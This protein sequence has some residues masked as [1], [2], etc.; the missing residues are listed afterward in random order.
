M[1]ESAPDEESSRIGRFEQSM[2]V[3][4][5]CDAPS[6]DFEDMIGIEFGQCQ[7]VSM[8]NINLGADISLGPIEL[9]IDGQ[10]YEFS[11]AA[12][13]VRLEHENADVHSASRYRHVLSEGRLAASVSEKEHKSVGSEF[14]LD[15]RATA[16]GG[17]GAGISGFWK[18]KS[19]KESESVVTVQPEIVF[20]EPTGQ[21]LWQVG[22]PNGDPRRIE[23]DLRGT[24]ISS[25][26]NDEMKPLCSLSARDAQQP[27]TGRVSIEASATDFRLRSKSQRNPY[28]VS[29]AV[30]DSVRDGLAEDH[31]AYLKRSR[32]AEDRLKERV[33]ALALFEFPRRI[34]K[35]PMINLAERRFVVS[36][37]SNDDREA[38]Q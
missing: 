17:S 28:K 27:V 14:N 29:G 3:H 23:R 25:Y 15:G 37:L 10:P 18:R 34:A 1:V 24:V 13:R 26:L 4:A 21:G 9:I 33:A 11:L 19:G 32:E 6:I 5:K 16:A 8:G 2:P 38:K 12:F 31:K 20:V 30:S 22:G 7:S 35:V 36:P